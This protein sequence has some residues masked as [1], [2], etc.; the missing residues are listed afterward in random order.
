VSRNLK[1]ALALLMIS[2]VSFIGTIVKI[3]MMRGG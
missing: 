2:L 3:W 1:T